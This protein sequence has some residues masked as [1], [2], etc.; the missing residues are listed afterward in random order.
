MRVS[1]CVYFVWMYLI[2][3][4]IH[5]QPYPTL[6]KRNEYTHTHTH[7]NASNAKHF[8][9]IIS[10]PTCF[11]LCALP[12]LMNIFHISNRH[13]HCVCVCLC[14]IHL[15][16][17]VFLF[18]FKSSPIVC[19]CLQ[20]SICVLGMEYKKKVHRINMYG[21]FMVKLYGHMVFCERYMFGNWLLC[22]EPHL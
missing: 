18:A 3:C 16:V 13:R 19:V 10:M 14:S 15:L 22:N 20:A 12:R 11:H 21:L 9:A 17:H 8:E 6:N 5:C 7:T 2:L 1:V 4:S